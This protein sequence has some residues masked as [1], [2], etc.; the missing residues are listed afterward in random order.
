MSLRVLQLEHGVA[1]TCAHG[2]GEE[3]HGNSHS[4]GPEGGHAQAI[5]EQNHE[6]HHRN[7]GIHAH[8]EPHVAALH[9]GVHVVVDESHQVCLHHVHQATCG[10]VHLLIVALHIRIQLGAG[11]TLR[12]AEES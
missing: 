10:L 6:N 2:Q 9:I 1:E 8:T 3:D 11:Q 4:D 7:R 5:P 12:L